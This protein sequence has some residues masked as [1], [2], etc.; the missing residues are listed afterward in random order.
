M[1]GLNMRLPSVL[2]ALIASAATAQVPEIP[3]AGIAVK[4]QVT[5]LRDQSGLL[6]ASTVS[7]LFNVNTMFL[8]EQLQKNAIVDVRGA[9]T[10]VST[11][12]DINNLEVSSPL[13]RLITEHL[14]HHL[15]LRGWSIVES[16]LV[17]ELIFTDDGDFGMTR[18]DF[19]KPVAMRAQNVVTGTYAVTKDGILVT[20]KM[21]DTN[22]GRLVSSAQTRIIRDK[23]SADLVLPGSAT[24]GTTVTVTR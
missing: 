4:R 13:G 11:I 12:M 9:E 18:S 6:E 22:S 16:K 8:A 5:I 10:V 7:G 24:A 14:A 23:F 1:K 19:R 20:L 3:F 15:N 2:I 17:K 21:V